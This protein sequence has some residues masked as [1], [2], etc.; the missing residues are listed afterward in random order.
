MLD[1]GVSMSRIA[2]IIWLGDEH[3]YDKKVIDR[4][5]RINNEI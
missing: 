2:Q 4:I 1:A 5:K 3:R